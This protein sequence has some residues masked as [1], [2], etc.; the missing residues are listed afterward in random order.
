[1]GKIKEY[2]FTNT[3]KYMQEKFASENSSVYKELEI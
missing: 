2:T 3:C 1:M